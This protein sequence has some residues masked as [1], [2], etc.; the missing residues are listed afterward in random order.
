MNDEIIAT[1]T[2]I[3]A[4]RYAD[5]SALFVAGSLIRGEGTA[6]SDLDLVVPGT[7]AGVSGEV[8][9]PARTGA[10]AGRG[11]D[12]GGAHDRG[13]LPGPLE[14]AAGPGDVR[15]SRRRGA[16]EP[17]RRA[18]DAARGPLAPGGVGTQR[19]EGSR[20]VEALMT[21]VATRKPPHRHVLDSVTAACEVP[22]CGE[23]APSLLPPLDALTHVM[24]PAAS[25]G[26]PG[27]RLPHL[28][29]RDG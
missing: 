5:C 25:L 10:A 16:H 18:R 28:Q 19:P 11:A 20:V 1:A 14:A 15:A 9:R 12:L 6:H 21:G 7:Q 27:E 3:R 29:G 23:P 8:A 24:R 22:L 17:R 26:T 4:Q 2:A 13:P